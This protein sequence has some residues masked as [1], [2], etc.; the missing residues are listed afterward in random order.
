M[1][2]KALSDTSLTAERL[3]EVLH[4]EPETG[5]FTWRLRRGCRAKGS[6]AGA[7]HHSGYWRIRV[8][9]VLYNAHRLAW[10]YMTGEWPAEELDHINRDNADNRWANLR[11]AT[12]SQNGANTIRP[13]PSGFRGVKKI[14]G[15]WRATIMVQK[16]GIFLGYYSTPEEAH[17]AYTNAARTY[18]GNYLAQ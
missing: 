2:M 8:D 1:P 17:A 15:R 7:T 4:Y 6:I 18:F 13:N 12:R 16:R 11:E 5:V 10:L 14:R 9:E 3:R